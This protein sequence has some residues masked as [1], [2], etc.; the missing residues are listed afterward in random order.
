MLSSQ[1]LQQCCLAWFIRHEKTFE[2]E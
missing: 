2:T 1:Y